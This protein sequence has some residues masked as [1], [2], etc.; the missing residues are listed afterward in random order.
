MLVLADDLGYGDLGCFG[1]K[2]I[3][4]PHIDALAR[5]GMRW[6]NWYA[7]SPE[8]APSRCSLLTGLHTGHAHVRANRQ[9]GPESQEP[10]PPQSTTLAGELRKR[11]YVTGLVGKWALG[12]AASGSE[13]TQLGFDFFFGF[14]CQKQAHNH[15]PAY[16]WSSRGDAST[17]VPGST[18]S[19][20]ML[21]GNDP[22]TRAEAVY[23]GDLFLKEAIEFIREHRD[24][25]FFLEFATPNPHL[26]LQIP[27]DA[28]AEY[29]G[30]LPDEP[31]DGSS[32][33]LPHPT[34]H[35]AYAAMVSRLDRDVGRLVALID[36]LG[37]AERTLVIVT[38]DN[39][40][41]FERTGGAD[42]AFFESAGGLRGLKGSVYEGGLRVPFVVRWPA[43]VKPGT[44][45]EIP[46]AHYDLFPTLLRLAE[47]APIR[48]DGVSLV[49]AFKDPSADVERECLYFEYPGFGGQQAVR[50]GDIKAVRRN[51]H[52]GKGSIEI[53]DLRVDPRE[54]ND[55]ADRSP[56]L[57]AR[58]KALF[59]KHHRDSRE[60]PFPA[61]DT[62]TS[63]AAPAK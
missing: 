25:P 8:C 56:D 43:H 15:Y 38:S 33:Y 13:P 6:T 1:Q 44:T 18:L 55:I 57:V 19:K 47:V 48:S 14:L 17:R 60:F 51:M 31:Y 3:R 22:A 40:P 58:A 49:N 46:A 27:D 32:G 63:E 4:T 36:E 10:L 23:S 34:P 39:G 54:S 45:S 50:F 16:L 42:S 30:K 12:G 52:E 11:G 7:S 62:G 24:V 21:E 5:E 41:T 59:A 53:Y 61:I 37:L 29:R 2:L 20:V 35:A 28:L 26:A 9:V